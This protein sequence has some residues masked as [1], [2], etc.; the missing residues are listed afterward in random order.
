M[1]SVVTS[2]APVVSP[3]PGSPSRKRRWLVVGTVVVVVVAVVAG[4]LVARGPGAP[5]PLPSHLGIT[6]DRAVPASVLAIPLLN[7]NGQTTSLGAFRGKIVVL[8]S[9]LTSCQETCPLTTGAFL[10]MERDLSA[11]GL[12][13][14]VIFIEASVDP[15]RDVPERLAAYARITGTSWPLLTGTPSNLASMWHYFGI[16]YQKVPEGSPPGIDWQTGKP[17]TYDVNHSDGFIVFD[18]KMDERFVTGAAPNL[19]GHELQ[20]SLQDMLD[21]QGFQNLLHPAHDSWTIPEGLQAI[22][23]LAGRTIAQKN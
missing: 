6:E 4:V 3:A 2:P 20:G 13:G 7:Q 16:Y 19:G 14:K 15:G 1:A 17:Y 9:F 21:A 12:A 5:G 11:A 18:T 8:T 10:D 22:G 23:W